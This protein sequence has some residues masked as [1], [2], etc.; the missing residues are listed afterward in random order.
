[1]DEIVDIGLYASYALIIIC[2]VLAVVMPLINSF[3][4]PKGLVKPL[5][6]FVALLVIIFIGYAVA[7]NTPRG[8]ATATA[9]QWVGGTLIAMY[10]LTTVAIIGILYTEISKV[11]K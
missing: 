1:M 3:G 9:S 10:I 6:G 8:D 2:T 11:F 5:L 7:D 4:N